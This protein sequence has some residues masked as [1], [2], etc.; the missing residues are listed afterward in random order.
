MVKDFFPVTASTCL[1]IVE[2]VRGDL[3]L[4]TDDLAE[5]E[6]ATFKS[7]LVDVFYPERRLFSGCGVAH[8]MSVFFLLP[9]GLR[10]QL[11]S[12]EMLFLE[13]LCQK[14][15]QVNAQVEPA[16]PMEDGVGD[17]ADDLA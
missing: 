15:V 4:R 2:L 1:N 9:C 8:R 10:R 6:N 14:R 12:A 7:N 11:G 16:V 17:L 5:F 13:S 3:E